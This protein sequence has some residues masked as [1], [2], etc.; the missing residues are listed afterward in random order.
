[1][2][3]SAR[4]FDPTAAAPLGLAVDDEWLVRVVARPDE[5]RDVVPVAYVVARDKEDP[6]NPDDL[7]AWASDQLA[8][9]ARP[10]E[11][12]LIDELPRTSVG[13]VRQ[14]ATGN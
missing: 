4:P 11:W 3:D 6:P 2:V 7:A 5:I 12:H 14:R 10:R 8:P 1:M 13:K 9:Q